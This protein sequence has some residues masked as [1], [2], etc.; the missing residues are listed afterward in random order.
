MDNQ[1]KLTDDELCT[2][3]TALEMSVRGVEKY[4]EDNGYSALDFQTKRVYNAMQE[5]H[6]KLN[7]EYF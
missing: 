2:I 6:K 4:A 3:Q 1:V 7:K 5:L